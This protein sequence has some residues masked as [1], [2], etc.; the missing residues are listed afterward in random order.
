MYD[1][2]GITT[3]R[4]LEDKDFLKD[5]IAFLLQK[6]KKVFVSRHARDNLHGHFSELPD[7]NYSQKFDLLLSI[8]G[9]GTI[10]RAARN[11]K[12]LDTPILGINA[13]HLGFLANITVTHWKEKL[14]KVF[15][16]KALTVEKTLCKVQQI[17]N[18]K[19]LIDSKF[20]NEI[21]L[22]Y[23]DIAR[24][25][26]IDAK[27]DKKKLCTYNADGLIIA[28]PTGSTAYN[29]AA[30]G[31]IVYPSLS[32]IILT[33]ICSH[34]FTQKPIVLPGDKKISLHFSQNKNILNLTIDGQRSFK[35]E[36][37]DVVTIEAMKQKLIFIKFPGQHFIKTLRQ[38]LHWGDSLR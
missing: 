26:T 12:H 24:V 10:L 9:D 29:L 2:I 5:V 18:D 4:H 23:S 20:L 6:G 16:G 36:S 15:S 8:G 3:K 31:P 27:I 11:L 35:V 33:P 38:K 32:A 1:S 28:T 37:N 21:V 34:S 17:R 30:G 14:D 7:I 25:I 22:S 19:V 13:G